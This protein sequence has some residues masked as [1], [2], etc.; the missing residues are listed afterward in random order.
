MERWKCFIPVIAGCLCLG[1]TG[2]KEAENADQGTGKENRD[3]TR[4]EEI[5]PEEQEEEAYIATEA[6]HEEGTFTTGYGE[7]VRY[8]FSVPELIRE[9]DDAERIN[10]EISEKVMTPVKKSVKQLENGEWPEY[11]ECSWKCCRSGSVLSLVIELRN[12]YGDKEIYVY[13]YNPKEDRQVTNEEVLEEKG[14]SV[15]EYLRILRCTAADRFDN[16]IA[17]FAS[18]GGSLWNSPVYEMR[19]RSVSGENLNLSVPVY[20]DDKG[21]LHAVVKLETPAGGGIHT[22]DLILPSDWSLSEEKIIEESG[23]ICKLEENRVTVLFSE[24]CADF[25][26]LAGS[27]IEKDI[28][29]EIHG[30]YGFYTDLAIGYP[31]NCGFPYL[32]LMDRNGR[33]SFCDIYQAIYCGGPDTVTA[34]GPID[35]ADRIS[36]IEQGSETGEFVLAAE[37]DL[38]SFFYHTEY[39]S[40]DGGEV[41]INPSYGELT[42]V[43]RE[44]G[45]DDRGFILYGGM[46]EEGMIYQFYT[47]NGLNGCFVLPVS[48]YSTGEAGQPMQMRFRKDMEGKEENFNGTVVE[49]Y[50]TGAVG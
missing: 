22:V 11:S 13:N 25:P 45:Y 18:E 3:M 33:V 17:A 42:I 8:C 31:G 50:P 46:T 1:L 36:E 27:G 14:L 35:G 7:Q 9:S 20:P 29:Y 4:E 26:R 49:L 44:T 38:G 6:Y 32:L 15:P 16:N 5:L 41:N 47:D 43:N 19:Q 21:R 34:V 12:D 10:E 30:L 2:C 39:L 24:E 48:G 40:E 23:M 37:S 28:P